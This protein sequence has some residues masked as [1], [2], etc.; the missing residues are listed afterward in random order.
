VKRLAIIPARSGSKGLENKNIRE[1]CGKPLVAYTIEAAIESGIFD[2]VMVSTDSLQYAEIAK[3]YG[4]EV[5]ELRPPKLSSDNASSMDVILHCLMLYQN[6]GQDFEWVCLLQPTSPMRNENHIK[7]AFCLLNSQNANSVVSVCKCEHSPLWCNRI[8]KDL[9][10]DHFLNEQ[11]M[12]IPRQLLPQ[13]YRLNGAIYVGSSN[14][15]KNNNSF[16][17]ERTVAY[18][19]DSKS[20]VDIDNDMDFEFVEF[21]MRRDEERGHE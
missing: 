4:A 7:E 9:R 5:P 15:V 20:S 21:M 8:E 10:I 13:Y 14:F 18:I 2:K 3:A 1:L 12:N 17:G 16:F 11:V 6:L 19:M